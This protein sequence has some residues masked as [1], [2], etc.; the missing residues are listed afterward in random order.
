MNKFLSLSSFIYEL[1]LNHAW[2]YSF[3][4]LFFFY[5]D[6][7]RFCC[8][9]VALAWALGQGGKA[10]G[11]TAEV[12]DAKDDQK[13]PVDG[14]CAEDPPV[15]VIANDNPPDFAEEGPGVA[16]FIRDKNGEHSFTLRPKTWGGLNLKP[17]IFMFKSIEPPVSQTLSDMLG[18]LKARI[19]LENS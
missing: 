16:F 4:W 19:G 14:H 2:L 18:D 6:F 1:L 9:S 11:R 5:Q 15:E 3:L 17:S 7:L 8:V 10:E 12:D 13:Q